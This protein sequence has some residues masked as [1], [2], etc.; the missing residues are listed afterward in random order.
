MNVDGNNYIEKIIQVPFELPLPEGSTLSD[1]L[2]QQI[3]KIFSKVPEEDHDQTYFGNIYHDGL[4]LFFRTPRDVIRLSNAMS[5]TFPSIIHDVNYVDFLAIE[6]IR[7]FE[8]K[9]YDAIRRNPELFCGAAE[10]TMSN[11]DTREKEKISTV[12]EASKVISFES[13]GELLSR[14]FPKLESILGNTYYGGDHYS[15]WR[16]KKRICSN[17][18]FPIYFRLSLASDSISTIEIKDILIFSSNKNE[19]SQWLHKLVQKKL[20]TGR[21]KLS[22]VLDRILDYID[23][24]SNEKKENIILSFFEVGVT[25]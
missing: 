5:V 1:L 25:Y 9:V 10:S 15:E 23:E 17:G 20:S 16:K 6:C 8:P 13:M 21:S 19:L 2:I 11:Q 22:V 14:L 7:V 18:H 4:K 24:L 12:I 3:N